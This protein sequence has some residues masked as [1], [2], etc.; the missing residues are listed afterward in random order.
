MRLPTD[1]VLLDLELGSDV[2]SVSAAIGGCGDREG[3][4]LCDICEV[5]REEGK[6]DKDARGFTAPGGPFE[7][8]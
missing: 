1:D 2:R 4:E 3:R 7:I 6:D 5:E 8:V